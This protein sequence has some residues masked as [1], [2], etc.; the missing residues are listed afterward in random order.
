MANESGNMIEIF[1]AG[2]KA[3]AGQLPVQVST[4][5]AG[6]V[7]AEHSMPDVKQIGAAAV[8][9][10]AGYYFWRKHKWLGASGGAAL[11]F[12]AE[13]LATGADVKGVLADVGA[14]G[15]GVVGG[16]KYKKHPFVGW[17]LGTVLG[18]VAASFVPGSEASNIRHGR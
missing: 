12:A 5:P 6:M 9:A 18:Q 11:G 7:K 8:G 4:S 16:L 3:A 14:A 2:M 15:L 13:R 1:G 10:G 17:L